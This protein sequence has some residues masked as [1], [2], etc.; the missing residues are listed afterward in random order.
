MGTWSGKRAPAIYG[1]FEIGKIP[2]L[3]SYRADPSNAIAQ[4]ISVKQD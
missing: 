4:L 1:G 2:T 3:K